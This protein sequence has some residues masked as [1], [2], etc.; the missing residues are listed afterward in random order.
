MNREK[1]LRLV[2]L[3]KQREFDISPWFFLNEKETND[4]SAQLNS[5]YTKRHVIALV[6]CDWTDDI[7]CY[8][9]SG[10]YA[11]QL[12]FIHDYASSGW[13]VND[14]AVFSSFGDFVEALLIDIEFKS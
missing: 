10:E 9:I 11:G 2:S 3:M 1:M 12:A 14:S 5:K 8:V 4:L 7:G 13:E 6:A